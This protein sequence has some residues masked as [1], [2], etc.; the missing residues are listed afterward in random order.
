MLSHEM[1]LYKMGISSC[2]LTL[3]LRAFIGVWLRISKQLYGFD[4]VNIYFEMKILNLKYAVFVH[5]E[6]EPH[7]EIQL[8]DKINIHL[9][10]VEYEL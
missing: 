4:L 5:N 8:C 1:G 7:V 9:N 6:M 10:H 3:N 2:L